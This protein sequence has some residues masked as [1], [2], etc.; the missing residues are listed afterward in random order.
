MKKIRNFIEHLECPSINGIMFGDETIQLLT[1]DVKWQEPIRYTIN[2]RGVKVSIGDLL[3]SETISWCSCAVLDDLVD[4]D[5][6][7]RVLAGEGTYGSDGFLAIIEVKTNIT[8]WLAFFKDSNPFSKVKI[9]ENK[10][11]AES[12]L[13]CLWIFNI[14][15]PL[16]CIVQC[17]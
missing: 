4:R 7:I 12:T 17:R 10:L 15:N 8:I 11:Y 3:K 14:K 1:V 5:R 13:G 16:Q 6:S 2:Q 9:I